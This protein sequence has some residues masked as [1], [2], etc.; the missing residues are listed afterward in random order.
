M[1]NNKSVT[2]P[3]QIRAANWQKAA[4]A[5]L[6]DEKTL[7]YYRATTAEDTG[8]LNP[9][10]WYQNSELGAMNDF[11][12]SRRVPLDIQALFCLFIAEF[13]LTDGEIDNG[14]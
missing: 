4:K 7:Y 3:N 12:H 14:N 9:Y 2:N 1:A 11:A 10:R 6:N 5:I 8:E 13:I